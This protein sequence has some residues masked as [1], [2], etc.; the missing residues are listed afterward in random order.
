MR[1][2]FWAGASL[3]TAL[4]AASFG[5]CDPGFTIDPA[6]FCLD[7]PQDPK[8]PKPAGAG[9]GGTG[10]TGGSLQG[11]G[12][13]GS[14]GIGGTGGTGGGGSAGAPPACVMPKVDCGGVCVDLALDDPAHCGACG[15]ACGAG[16]TCSQGACSGFPV[17]QNVIAP[18]GLA[19]DETFVYFTVPVQDVAGSALPVQRVPREGGAAAEVPFLGTPKFRA[20]AVTLTNGQLIFGDLDSRQM[21]QGA[22]TGGSVTPHPA[23]VQPAVQQLV[24]SGGTL[25]W[26][27]FDGGNSRV[28]RTP[29]FSGGA[30]GAAG[31]SGAS[32]ASGAGGAGGAGGV[33]ELIFQSGRINAVDGID[34]ANV[35]FW[36][37]FDTSL[38]PTTGLWRKIGVE[39]PERL[40]DVV[41]MNTVEVSDGQVFVVDPAGGIRKVPVAAEAPATPT[42][43]VAAADTGGLVQN[44]VVEQGKL[45]WLAFS[46]ANQ[47]ELHRATLDGAEAR[48][49]GRVPVKLPGYWAA[50]IGPAQMAFFGGFVYFSDPGTVQGDLQDDNLSGVKGLPDG[51]IYRLPQ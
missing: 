1:A 13:A 23:G 50:P 43:V 20:R 10:G 33:Q 29:P 35:V 8:C 27:L 42:T 9:G 5:A 34:E 31:A 51:A 49:L 40:L 18:F 48:V 6:G 4:V 7:E 21:L 38:T 3:G 30:G 2:R 12:G 19:V 32:G 15:F 22:A 17:V 37:N 46:A 11:A 39:A 36:V 24:V 14:A 41:G 28:R 44:L 25:L 47:L 45:Y 26:N 16:S